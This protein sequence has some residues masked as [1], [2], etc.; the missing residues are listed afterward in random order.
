MFHQILN[1]IMLATEVAEKKETVPLDL[2]NSI[3]EELLDIPKHVQ[4]TIKNVEE[5]CSALANL[6]YEKESIYL[7]AMKEGFS[8][9]KEAALK[10]K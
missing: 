3:R 1:L 9:A 4:A 2:I 10:I 6:L 5:D 7:L 8:V